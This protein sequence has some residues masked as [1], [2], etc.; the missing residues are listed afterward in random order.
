MFESIRIFL[1][2]VT[3]ALASYFDL[4]KRE[5][6]DE[7]NFAAI[8]VG[9]LLCIIEQKYIA[10]LLAI[11]IFLVGYVIYLSGKIGGGD[12]KLFVAI[13]LLLPLHKNRILILDL[14]LIGSIIA[15]FVISAYYSLKY[16]MKGVNLNDIKKNMLN[17]MLFL[18]LVVIYSLLLIFIIDINFIYIISI[19][20]IGLFCFLFILFEHGI[21]KE[22]FLKKVKLDELEEDEVVAYEFLDK[23]VKD[24]IYK[25][26]FIAKGILTDEEI[27]KLKE[28]RIKEI[29]V[30][31]NMPPFAPF[32]FLAVI[33]VFLFPEYT[34]MIKMIVGI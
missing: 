24:V 28:A 34:N 4:K 3:T 2:I 15:L 17:A 16:I 31:K 21:K 1:L 14:L 9:A 26:K 33:F 27:K 20:I 10:F 13:S 8:I 29:L 23:K 7:V 11:F 19:L 30:Y 25:N 6:P 12:I 18:M 22:F 5:I 32:I